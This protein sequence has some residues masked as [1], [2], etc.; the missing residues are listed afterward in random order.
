MDKDDGNYLFVGNNTTTLFQ[1]STYP[2]LSAYSVGVTA[3]TNYVA[4][5][6]RLEGHVWVY[7]TGS[8][9]HLPLESRR[10]ILPVGVGGWDIYGFDGSYAN[11]NAIYETRFDAA[12]NVYIVQN[13]YYLMRV[14]SP[15]G[16][17]VATTGNDNT[18]TNGTFSV[19]FGPAINPQPISAT[20]TA[21]TTA[22]FTVTADGAATLHY[23][24]LRNG[25]P[26]V[27]SAGHIGGATSATLYV[28]NAQCADVGNYQVVVT[29]S[30]GA[31]TSLPATLTVT[32]CPTV[33]ITG[34]QMLGDGTFQL[35]FFG[36]S[37]W[38]YQVLMWNNVTEPLANWT[39]LTSGT[40]GGSSVTYADTGA[41]GQRTRYY[42]IKSTSP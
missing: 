14:F 33:V 30:V 35:T 19:Q 24:W 31:V 1:S 26:L 4:V 18:G 34:E 22:K 10:M 17:S 15:G 25:T 16:A 5:G 2:A 32:G 11:T 21:G 23:Q 20:N 3:D 28:T 37:G 7:P 36:P 29:N 39:S 27:N 9:N 38:S 13:G 41:T 8:S 6:K 12:D 42:R 40:F